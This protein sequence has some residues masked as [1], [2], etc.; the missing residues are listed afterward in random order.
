MTEIE[1]LLK[2]NAE[3]IQGAQ[4]VLVGGGVKDYAEYRELVGFIRGLS[5]ANSHFEDLEEKVKKENDE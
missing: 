1:Y 3:L 2:Q 5:R 4:T